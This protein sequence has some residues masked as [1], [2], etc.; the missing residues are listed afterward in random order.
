MEGSQGPVTLCDE[1]GV[2]QVGEQRVLIV[3]LVPE[4]H[5]ETGE[6]ERARLSSTDPVPHGEAWPATPFPGGSPGLLAKPWNW[7]LEPANIKWG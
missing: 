6:R 5:Q 3:T 4:K 7:R 1:D 2:L